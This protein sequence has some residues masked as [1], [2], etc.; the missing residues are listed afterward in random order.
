M[1]HSPLCREDGWTSRSRVTW[2]ILN[3]WGFGQSQQRED[4]SM[5]QCIKTRFVGLD[6]HKDTIV[7]AVAELGGR[8][9]AWSLRRLMNGRP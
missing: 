2:V 1:R 7:V 3:A 5:T 9:H 8:R 4:W 6:V